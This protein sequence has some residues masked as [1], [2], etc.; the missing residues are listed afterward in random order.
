[1][2]QCGPRTHFDEPYHP[3][4]R[5]CLYS[6]PESTHAQGEGEIHQTKAR[7]PFGERVKKRP[8]I[9]ERRGGEAPPDSRCA[10]RSPQIL[11]C[12]CWGL[13]DVYRVQNFGGSDLPFRVRICRRRPSRL[14]FILDFLSRLVCRLGQSVKPNP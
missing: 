2:N 5:I 11:G 9:A 13:C 12:A 1:M 14:L 3:Q 6:Q 4:L 10:H 7:T 8:D